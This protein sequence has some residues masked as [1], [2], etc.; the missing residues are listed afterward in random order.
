MAEEV[1]FEPT[2]PVKVHRFSRAASSTTPALLHIRGDYISFM[3]PFSTQ[4][5]KF[6]VP[7]NSVLYDQ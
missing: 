3:N 4:S 5:R 6:H 1:G 2:V 7:G